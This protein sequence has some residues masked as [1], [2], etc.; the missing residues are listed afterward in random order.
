M[1]EIIKNNEI[2]IAFFDAKT[3]DKEFFD[4]ENENYGYE[5]KY[6][7]VKLSADT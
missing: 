4:Q 7:P 1:A 6:F 2:K 3:Y 5:I